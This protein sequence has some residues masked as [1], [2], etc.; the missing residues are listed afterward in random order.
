MPIEDFYE[1]YY[2]KGF[3]FSKE[4]LTRYAL[5]L[6]TK[7]LVILSGI[8]GTG[9]TKIAQLFDVLDEP[10][11][12]PRPNHTLVDDG[13]IRITVTD[14]LANGD[15]RGNFVFGQLESILDGQDLTSIRRKIDQILA[16]PNE[17]SRNFGELIHFDVQTPKEET[18]T[19]AIYF[20]RAENPLVRVRA[21]S[22]RGAEIEYDSRN[23]FATNYQ[24]GDVVRLERVANRTL[25]IINDHEGE[26][27]DTRIATQHRQREL[28]SIENKCFIPVKSNWTDTDALMGYYNP[29]DRTYHMT[30]LLKF[31]LT[32]KENPEKPFFLILDEMNLSKVE[33]YFSDFLSCIESRSIG[34]DGEIIQQGITLYAGSSV[35]ETNDEEYNEIPSVIEIPVNLFIT[36]TV[37]IDD[38]TFMFSPKVLD[39]ANVIEFNDVYIDQEAPIES[40]FNLSEFPDFSLVK[41]SQLNMLEE[42]KPRSKQII[43]D[44]NNILKKYRQ[45]FGYRVIGE[46]SHWLLNSNEYVDQTE[47]IEIQALDIQILQKVLPKLHGSYGKLGELISELLHYLSKSNTIL[48]NFDRNAINETLPSDTE[49]PRSVEKLKEMHSDL[50]LHGFASYLS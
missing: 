28:E 38:S 42:L 4:L 44:I 7:P 24:V 3:K 37:N 11:I 34:D 43:R 27:E 25:R 30:K 12:E 6:K 8:S 39:R 14:G 35:V 17:T 10:R 18:I 41:L 5:S 23:Y 47:A 49:F 29:L 2:Q 20:Q 31:L 33:H 9:K 1:R 50:L 22:K 45:H 16:N 48:S 13:L 15:G 46:I 32:A 19:L 26:D 36:G 40:S 21:K